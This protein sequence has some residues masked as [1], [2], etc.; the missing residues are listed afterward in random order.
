MN[1]DRPKKETVVT[2]RVTLSW[3]D[4]RS[5]GVTQVTV[6]VEGCTTSSEAIEKARKIVEPIR[7]DHPK[8]T[9][10]QLEEWE[11]DIPQ[12]IGTGTTADRLAAALTDDDDE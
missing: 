6:Y 10:A 3:N 11:R 9:N 1:R 7:S 2:F 4:W 5:I 12:K 8:T